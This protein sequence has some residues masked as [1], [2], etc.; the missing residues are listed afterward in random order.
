MFLSS[1]SGRFANSQDEFAAT[2]FVHRSGFVCSQGQFAFSCVA[3][4]ASGLAGIQ[5]AC[6]IAALG[7][8]D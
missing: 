2:V 4:P 6:N 5:A 7:C 8:G 1:F 3:R